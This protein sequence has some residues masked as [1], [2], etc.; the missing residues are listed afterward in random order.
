MNIQKFFC[1]HLADWLYQEEWHF[2][3]LKAA[4]IECVENLPEDADILIRRL[5]INFP[6]K[7]PK[8]KIASFLSSHIRVRQ[9]FCRPDPKPKIVKFNLQVR[10]I[11]QPTNSYLP[12]LSNVSDLAE[13]LDL[14]YGQLD[15]LADLKRYDPAAP[16]YFNHYHYSLLRKRDGS[17]R[18]IES[19]KST[20]KQI[21]RKINDRILSYVAMHDAA[22]GFRKRRSCK[23]H[24]TLHAG[25]KYLHLFDL[26][27]CFQSIQWQH[28][29]H[30]FAGLGYA[31]AVA[32][33]LTALCTHTGY[34]N[35]ELLKQLDSDQRQRLR[36]RHLAQGAP[37]SPTLSNAVLF[38]LDKRLAGLAKSLQLDYSRYAD[39]LAFS[40][41][42]HRDWQFLEPLVGCI[43]LEQGFSLNYRKSRLI[44]PH[45][46]QKITGIV[47]NEKPNI[48]RRYYDRLKAVLTN[49]SR[50]GLRSQNRANHPDFRAHLLGSIQHVKSLNA[51]KGKKLEGIFK[52]IS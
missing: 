6:D 21:Q 31:P 36:Q 35:H 39:D 20:L 18:L 52:Q 51:A 45:Q 50:Y 32:R 34:A 27:H 38:S 12:V 2:T 7:P 15:W 40:G 16:G 41:N 47:I 22:H 23:T 46:R 24:A 42:V 48:D 28:V 25:K 1:S 9:W 26:A 44:K 3:T 33:N 43:C 8:E 37:S 30:I 29:Y 14:S 13:W 19:P 49:C 5:L 10:Q 11:H 17:A 4:C